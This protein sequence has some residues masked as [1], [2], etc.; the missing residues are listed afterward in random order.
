ME[1]MAIR[2]EALQRWWPTTQCL[3]LVEGPVE[4]AAEAVHAEVSR[5]HHSVPDQGPA[6]TSW[7]GVRAAAARVLGHNR[8]AAVSSVAAAW[9]VFAGLDAAFAAAPLFTN[10]P[11]FLL[12]LPTHSKWSVL[13]NNSFLCDGYDSLCHCLTEN[14]QLTTLHWI[15]HD[16]TTTAQPGAT[17]THRK[18]VKS[19]LVV[20]SVYVGQNDRRWLFEQYGPPLPEEDRGLYQA[21]RTRDRLDER[22]ML[23]LLDRLG[24][25]PWSEAFYALQE[26]P[27]YAVRYEGVASSILRRTRQQVL[28]PDE[29]RLP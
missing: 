6:A 10:I 16:A 25:R 23:D 28:D 24:A 1:A 20:R 14:H 22:H 26:K 18:W 21:A 5:W 9:E 11:T 29:G 7:E 4:A 19:S 27:C 17:F 12:V 13:W 8:S 2:T 15:A 3:D